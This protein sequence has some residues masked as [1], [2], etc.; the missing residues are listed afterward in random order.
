MHCGNF[1]SL[2]SNRC[3]SEQQLLKTVEKTEFWNWNNLVILR[4]EFTFDLMERSF[5]VIGIR[6]S[7]WIWIRLTFLW[8]K[9]D[10]KMVKNQILCIELRVVSTLTAVPYTCLVEVSAL[11]HGPVLNH[12]LSWIILCFSRRNCPHVLIIKWHLYD[13]FCDWNNH[14][15]FH[16]FYVS[17]YR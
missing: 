9:C 16:A 17:S 3:S 6:L 2:N 8:W 11:Q 4:G 12:P 10:F 13:V 1:C 7:C 14:L 15:P 5:T